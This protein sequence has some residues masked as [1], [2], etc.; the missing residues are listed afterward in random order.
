[1][2]KFSVKD[3]LANSMTDPYGVCELMDCL[4]AVFVVEFSNFF[5]IF[6]GFAGAWL[7]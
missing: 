2:L 6:Y 5:N 7:P 4:A 3:F 1:M